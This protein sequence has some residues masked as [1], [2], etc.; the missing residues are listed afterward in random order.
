AFYTP[1][2]RQ[3]MSNPDH[4][5]RVTKPEYIAAR[6]DKWDVTTEPDP[7]MMAE[8]DKRAL[9]AKWRSIGN[10]ML[11]DKI[12]MESIVAQLDRFDHQTRGARDRARRTG[13]SKPINTNMV[14]MGPPGTGKSTTIEAYAH[15]LA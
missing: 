6:T 1:A 9:R 10:T 7:S 11:D 4:T 3:A 5:L 14:V 2:A 15:R 8:K 13:T 12:G